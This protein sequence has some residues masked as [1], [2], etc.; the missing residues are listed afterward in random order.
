M[1]KGTPRAALKGFSRFMSAAAE[2]TPSP[3][4]CMS[5]VVS[6]SPQTAVSSPFMASMTAIMSAAEPATA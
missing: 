1:A 6:V 3:T 2:H 5:R 4:R